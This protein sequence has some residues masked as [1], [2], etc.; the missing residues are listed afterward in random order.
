MGHDCGILLIF[1]S[2]VLDSLCLLETDVFF[3]LLILHS[4]GHVMSFFLL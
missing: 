4:V 3:G 1:I 2:V